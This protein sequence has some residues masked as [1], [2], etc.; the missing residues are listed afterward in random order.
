MW[1]KLEPI[2]GALILLTDFVKLTRLTSIVNLLYV[3]SCEECSVPTAKKYDLVLV[4]ICN[5]MLMYLIHNCIHDMC[6]LILKSRKS[7]SV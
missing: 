4:T 5:A 3:T 2:I 7:V 1:I 6:K